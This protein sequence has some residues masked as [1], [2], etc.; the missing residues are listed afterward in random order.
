MDQILPEL[1]KVGGPAALVV[2]LFWS[3]LKGHVVVGPV[4]RREV[5]RADRLEGIADQAT[6]ALEALSR[7][8][9]LAV[10]LL[11]SVERK[12]A[13]NESAAGGGDGA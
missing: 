10:A 2:I 5:E 8:D 11:R 9:D 4:Y 7:R 1:W 13:E 3:L 6:S 12:A